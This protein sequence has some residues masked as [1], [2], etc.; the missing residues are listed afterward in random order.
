MFEPRV[1]NAL[2][3]AV[4][5]ASSSLRWAGRIGLWVQAVLGVVSASTLVILAA[6]SPEF[7]DAEGGNPGAAAA[8]FF[9]LGGVA[10][11]AIATYMSFR[12][13]RLS[14]ML[15]FAEPGDRPS[16]GRVIGLLQFGA[17]VNLVGLL[18]TVLG[19]QAIVGIVLIKSL[20]QPQLVIGAD[21]K[22]FV[23]SADLL[24][25][26]SNVNTIAAHSVG[27]A[28]ELWSIARMTR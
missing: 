12:Y 6:F 15:L 18:L 3:P 8:I 4:Q 21:P 10:A 28:T 7:S 5:K 27:L 22:Q 25:I 17:I 11:L 23:N 1:Q 19:A 26:Q 20:T 14:G 24:I 13:T 2:P 16:R 9:A